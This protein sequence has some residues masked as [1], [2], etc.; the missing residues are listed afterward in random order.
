MVELIKVG[1][2]FLVILL[3]TF[4]RTSLWISLLGATVLLGLLFRLPPL[5]IAEDVFHAALERKTLFLLGS[6]TAILL[7]SNL[8]KETGRIEKI[9]HGFRHLLGDIRAVV[10]LF[11]AIIGLMP[12]AGGALVSAP[13]V[14]P[15]CD[16]LNL[17]PERRTFINYWFRHVWEYVLPTFPALLLAATLTGIGLRR[18]CWIQLPLT[19]VSIL[20]GI[21]MGYWGVPK[22]IREGEVLSGR[23]TAWDLFLNLLPLLLSL[24]L[25]VGFQ[26][27]LMY[28]FGLTTLGIILFYKIGMEKVWRGLRESVSM[29]LFS[30]VVIVMGFK[31][32]LESSQAI[33]HI[34]AGLSM[35]E[36]P[37]W[38]VAISI[39]L[40]VGLI[41]GSTIA[42]PAIAF[43]ILIPLFQKNP[44]FQLYMMLSFASGISGTMLS[45]VHLCLVLTKDFFQAQW[46]G[47]YRLLWIPTASIMVV[48]LLVFLLFG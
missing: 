37:G 29:E 16:E 47:V 20:S 21:L 11:P 41:T 26:V 13:M 9:L 10:A 15:G 8:L 42:V 27:E 32:V 46:G 1:I 39:P 4:R 5:K 25:V 44:T 36:V 40:I 31:K 14:V 24:I 7:F 28:A 33:S 23:S 43:P 6:F 38:L 12:I 3:L 34:S 18:L 17:S 2:V 48:G 22:S 35:S 45:P 19:L 30:T